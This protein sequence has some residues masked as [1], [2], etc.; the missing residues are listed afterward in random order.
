MIHEERDSSRTLRKLARLA[1]QYASTETDG[2][3][4]TAMKGLSILRADEEGR[5]THQQTKPSVCITM[6]GAAW[7]SFG[8]KRYLFKAG[9][10]LVLAV[11]IAPRGAVFTAIEKQRYIGL[12]I[13][14]DFAVLREMADEMA[15]TKDD[16]KRNGYPLFLEA[17][18]RLLDCAHRA[19]RLLD[20]PKAIPMLYHGIIREFCYWLL[21]GQG[22]NRVSQLMGVANEHDRKIAQAIQSLRDKVGGVVHVADLAI[23]ANMSQATFHRRFKMATGVTPLQ[24]QKQLRLHKARRLMLFND[25]L[26]EAAAIDVGYVSVS[27]FS[28]EYTRMFGASPRRDVRAFKATRI[29]IGEL[30]AVNESPQGGFT[31][32]SLDESF[33]G[34]GEG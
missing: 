23:A 12:V 18:H 30:D 2:H 5:L 16:E 25:M 13:E 29:P 33:G 22:G 7:A 8:E 21:S 24:Y 19:L 26:V 28:R 34:S 3:I 17:E 32:A 1:V 9:Q 14:L 11:D 31:S 20:T 4:P 10:M 6:Q 15:L 27:Q